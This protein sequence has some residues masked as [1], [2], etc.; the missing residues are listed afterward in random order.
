MSEKP[1]SGEMRKDKGWQ[2]HTLV[3]KYVDTTKYYVQQ[4]RALTGDVDVVESDIFK[5]HENA[6][7]VGLLENLVI[8]GIRVG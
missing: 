5:S 3:F 7:W 6:W 4:S 1:Y 8:D 2:Q